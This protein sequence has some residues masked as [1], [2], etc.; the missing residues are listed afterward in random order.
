MRRRLGQRLVE[1]ELLD[2]EQHHQKLTA[3]VGAS[4]S[5]WTSVACERRIPAS[6]RVS[7]TCWWMGTSV[8][9]PPLRPC[10]LGPP[11]EQY[12][13]CNELVGQVVWHMSQMPR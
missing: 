7:R 13:C 3:V 9:A 5:A 2:R 10:P 6:D 4:Q 11:I 12:G 1:Q 8:L